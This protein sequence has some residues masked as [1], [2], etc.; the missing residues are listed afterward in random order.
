MIIH[1]EFLA[2][3]RWPLLGSQSSRAE[4]S[5][6]PH[7]FYENLLIG[8]RFQVKLAICPSITQERPSP[9]VIDADQ[10]H[11]LIEKPLPLSAVERL[12]QL[13][14]GF[15]DRLLHFEQHRRP[16][17]G[18][19]SALRATVFRVYFAQDNPPRLQSRQNA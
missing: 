19:E 17:F 14:V 16:L 7:R 9:V 4:T 15:I 2:V 1:L 3:R 11:K 5:P 12:H 18:Q 6:A 10:A 8:L 13:F